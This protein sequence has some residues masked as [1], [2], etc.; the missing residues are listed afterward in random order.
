MDDLRDKIAIVTGASSGIGRAAAELL[1]RR[2][3]RVMMFARSEEK[4]AAIASDQERLTYIAGDVADDS[5]LERLFRETEQRL[6]PCQILVNN[7]GVIDPSPV[8]EMAPGIWERTF[9]VNVR[10]AFMA[11]R[12]ALPAMIEHRRGAIVNVS[13]I[14]GVIGPEK[15][16]GFTAYCASKAAL[17][18]F[19][20]AV[21]VEVK[22]HGVRVN[23]V[24]PGSVDTPMWAEVS[25]GA[26]ADMTAAEVAETIVFLATDGS[27][28]INGQN[29]HVFS[30]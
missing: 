15:F 12:R 4:L 13:S 6:G 11:T 3:A 27:R 23:C 7:A 26:P 22:E 29:I 18:A 5:A 8:T 9:A 24:S 17:I 10:A 16:P 20:E 28:P 25:G 19:T 1:A 21:A 14:S 2:G 30:S